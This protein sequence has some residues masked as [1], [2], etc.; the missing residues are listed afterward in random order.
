MGSSVQ[1]DEIKGWGVGRPALPTNNGLSE[2]D[3]DM[4]KSYTSVSENNNYSEILRFTSNRQAI[5]ATLN[6]KK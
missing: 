5:A 4:V 1:H 3:Y 6:V 2:D